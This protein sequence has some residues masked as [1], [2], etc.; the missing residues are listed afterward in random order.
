MRNDGIF[1]ADSGAEN[2]FQQLI[3]GQT[4]K[5]AFHGTRFY[6]T[7]SILNFGL[8]QHLNKTGLF[9]DGLYFAQELGETLF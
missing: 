5:F 2:R 1:S 9:G 8:N 3:L 6:N 7:F 4:T